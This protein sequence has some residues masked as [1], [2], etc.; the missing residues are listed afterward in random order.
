VKLPGDGIPQPGVKHVLLAF[1]LGKI[2]VSHYGSGFFLKAR[3]RRR[4]SDSPEGSS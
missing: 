3:L 1:D 2:E 4:S